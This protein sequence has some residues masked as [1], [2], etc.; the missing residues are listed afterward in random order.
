MAMKKESGWRL[1]IKDKTIINGNKK[2]PPHRIPHKLPFQ[3]PITGE[4][5]HHHRKKW[6]M[7]HHIIFCYLFCKN[8]DFMKKKYNQAKST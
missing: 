6:R 3:K 4:P 2:C 1:D 8:Y 7:L 5:C